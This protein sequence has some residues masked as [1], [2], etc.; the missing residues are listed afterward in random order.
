MPPRPKTATVEPGLTCA[1]LSTAP[2]PA[3]TTQPR[4]HTSA[5]GAPGLILDSGDFGQ[6]DVLGKAARAHV[7]QNGPAFQRKSRGAV[8]HD[9]PVLRRAQPGA[10]VGLVRATGFAGPAFG[11]VERDDVVAGAY[12]GDPA[13]HVLDDATAFVPEDHREHSVRIRARQCECVRLAHARGDDPHQYLARLGACEIH[14]LD[15]QRSAGLPGNRRSGFHVNRTA[16]M[17]HPCAVTAA[18]VPAA[19]TPQ[20]G[21]LTINCRPDRPPGPE[22]RRTRWGVTHCALRYAWAVCS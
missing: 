2:M 13:T 20:R 18:C 8:L 17:R 1:V 12:A 21:A 7:M 3:V 4:R 15:R 9:S 5:S 11:H 14:R 19:G 22:P 16:C 6:H 10:L